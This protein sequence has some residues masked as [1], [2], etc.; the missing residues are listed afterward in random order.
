MSNTLLYIRLRQL[1][2]EAN[3]LGLYT[4][5]FIAIAAVLSFISYW[6][7]NHNRQAWLIVILLSAICLVIQYNRKDKAFIYK[8]LDKPHL[9]LFLEY[10]VLTLPFSITSIASKNWFCFPLLL[11]ALASIPLL[12]FQS[13]HRAVF[14]DLSSIIPASNY[15]WISGLRK[16]YIAFISLY[17]FAVAFSWVRIFPLFL[18]WFLTIM[19]SSFFLENEP[20]HIL[21]AGDKTARELLSGKIKVNIKYI[22]ILYSLPVMINAIFVQE[23]LIITLLFIPVQ[24]ALISFAICLK[25]SSYK[26]NTNLLGNNIAFS[27]I[28]MLSAVPYFLP[29]PVIFT[30]VYFFRAEKNLKTYLH[31]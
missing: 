24:L 2:R 1:N 15:E 17:L 7:Y 22:L 4:P 29:V 27:I 20:V 30:L 11:L 8:Q 25:Y 6:Q 19:V 26:P 31:D 12:K 9:Q 18:L 14:K 3:E 10:L 23:F 16:Q 28:A 13:K 21:R 5:I